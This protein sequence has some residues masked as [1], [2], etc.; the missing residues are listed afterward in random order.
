M[1]KVVFA[2]LVSAITVS[3]LNYSFNTT[4]SH[5]LRNGYM[6]ITSISRDHGG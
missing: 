1:E 3:S 5:L 4:E 6:A 2:I